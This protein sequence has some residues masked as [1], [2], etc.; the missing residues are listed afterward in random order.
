MAGRLPARR[1][2]RDDRRLESLGR[3]LDEAARQIRDDQVDPSL[4]KDLGMTPQAYRDFVEEYRKRYQQARRRDRRGQAG[5]APV[6][7]DR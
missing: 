2:G 1:L 5:V 7:P 3:A 4:L 6:G